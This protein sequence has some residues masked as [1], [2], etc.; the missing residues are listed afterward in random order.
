[1]TF[2]ANEY[3]MPNKAVILK[4]GRVSPRDFINLS[5]D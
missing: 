4:S 1:M 5:C 2:S 3:L